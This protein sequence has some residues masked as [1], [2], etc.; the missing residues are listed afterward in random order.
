MTT[1]TELEKVAKPVPGAFTVTIAA[2]VPPGTYEVRTIGRFGQSNARIFT[3]SALNELIDAGVNGAPDKAVDVPVNSVFNGRVDAN[4]YDHLKIPLKAGE[5]VIID[6]SAQRLQ[7]R[8]NATMILM[9][10]S[11]KELVR[12]KDTVGADPVIDFTAPA[13]GFYVLKVFDN[14]Y[15][16]GPDYFYRLSVTP[17]AYVD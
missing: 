8:L 4:T 9:S 3:V 7:S 10:P 12:A 2:D 14:V 1:P 6:C 5:R 15:G 16:G 11:G 17:S 13:E